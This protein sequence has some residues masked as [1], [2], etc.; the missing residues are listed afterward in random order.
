MSVPELTA[1]RARLDAARQRAERTEALCGIL[2]GQA[3][4]ERTELSE[5]LA[6][7]DR[8]IAPRATETREWGV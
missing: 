8:A 4:R 2:A 1:L 3:A 5:A 7:L 6:E